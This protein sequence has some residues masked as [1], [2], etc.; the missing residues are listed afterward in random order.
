MSQDNI[1]SQDEIDELLTAISVGGYE[2][3]DSTEPP[4][5]DMYGDK[6][7]RIKIYDFKRPDV[8]TKEQIRILSKIHE[9]ASR[10]LQKTLAQSFDTE[11]FRIAVAS[12]DQLQYEEY[13]R[14]INNP[15]LNYFFDVNDLVTNVSLELDLK[16]ITKFIV[17]SMDGIAKDKFIDYNEHHIIRDDEYA[18][19]I[20][21]RDVVLKVVNQIWET[22]DV[23]W[24]TSLGR[25]R[26]D[27]DPSSNKVQIDANPQFLTNLSLLKRC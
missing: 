23:H 22:L 25:S 26:D 17:R 27:Q 10:E 15:S 19:F 16:F 3:Q 6:H 5:R 2:D 1:L 21:D 14:S 8:L 24:N 18:E 20:K 12:V 9:Q 11:V 13:T 7:K 4:F